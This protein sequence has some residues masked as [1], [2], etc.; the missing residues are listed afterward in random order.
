[1][2]Q[3]IKEKLN[4]NTASAI[5]IAMNVLLLAMVGTLGFVGKDLY[6]EIRAYP[7]TT[8]ESD[9]AQIRKDMNGKAEKEN[10]RVMVSELRSQYER[11]Y[12]E[13]CRQNEKIDELNIYLRNR[14]NE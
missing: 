5:L 3:R 8:I 13:M 1:M 12:N 2:V 9:I 11:L 4:G 7:N 6:G 14:A 10:I